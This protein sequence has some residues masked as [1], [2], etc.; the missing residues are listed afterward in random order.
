MNRSWE[1]HWWLSFVSMFWSVYIKPYQIAVRFELIRCLRCRSKVNY[2]E[3]VPYDERY[4]V[5]CHGTIKWSVV[6]SSLRTASFPMVF[7]R[8]RFRR[9]RSPDEPVS[10]PTKWLKIVSFFLQFSCSR[11]T[12]QY[13]IKFLASALRYQVFHLLQDRFLWTK[14]FWSNIEEN[15]LHENILR[16]P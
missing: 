14:Y 10:W 1:P 5:R 13:P 15:I 2:T 7:P 6:R 12:L 9:L 11:L 8:N 16:S 3:V 4:G